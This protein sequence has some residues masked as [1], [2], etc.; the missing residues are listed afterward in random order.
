MANHFLKDK[1]LST[2]RR[3]P[4]KNYDTLIYEL[5]QNIDIPL[6]YNSSPLQ[7]N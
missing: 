1:Y 7:S 4:L 3:I 5:S 2:N 6:I